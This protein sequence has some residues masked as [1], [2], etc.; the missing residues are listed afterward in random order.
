MTQASFWIPT[1][2]FKMAKFI[3]ACLQQRCDLKPDMFY[4][5]CPIKIYVIL[6]SNFDGNSKV[7]T[8]FTHQA[9]RT[10]ATV[11]SIW[12]LANL[13]GASYVTMEKKKRKQD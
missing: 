4:I 8:E 2:E 11:F 1:F 7:Q 9:N 3:T 13:G 6:V 12:E 5:E 10:S